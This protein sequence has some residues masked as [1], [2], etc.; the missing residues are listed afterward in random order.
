MIDVATHTILQSKFVSDALKQLNELGQD[1]T[2][3][4]TNENSN[5]IGTLTDGDIRRGLLKGL[6]IT[7]KVAEFMNERFSFLRSNDYQLADVNEIKNRGITLIPVVDAQ[8]RILKIVNL[9]E[10]R[11]ILP[12]DTVIMAGGEGRRLRPLTEKVPKPL[13]KVGSKPILEHNLDRLVRF[14]VDDY[15][16]CVRYLGEQ[17]VDYFKDGSNKNIKIEY[18]WEDEPLGTIGAIKKISTF[19]HDHILLTNSDLLTN[20]DYEDFYLDFVGRQADLSVV[21]IPYSINVPYA[22]LE[23]NNGHIVSFKEKPTYTYYS[24]GGIYLLK[25]EILQYIPNGFFNATDL[26]ERLINNGHRVIS[27]P[28]HGYWLDIGKTEDY[29]RAQED[30]KYFKG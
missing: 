25:K 3:F 6:Q 27:Y 4:V 24:N 2:L 10:T 23:T 21:T 29:A 17:I 22:V 20:L 15:W 11:T 14:G 18:I 30:I 1:L 26:M 9:T 8:L 13:L 7:D 19:K 16:V 12:I 5:L 28:L